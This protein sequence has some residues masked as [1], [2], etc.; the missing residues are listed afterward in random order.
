[1]IYGFNSI[2]TYLNANYALIILAIL[3]YCLWREV[4]AALAGGIGQL[5][6][7]AGSSWYISTGES[8][9]SCPTVWYIVAAL[10]AALFVALPA[11]SYEISHRRGREAS[12]T[13]LSI[14]CTLFFMAGFANY[15]VLA[16]M[17]ASGATDVAIGS[18][19][20]AALS[21]SVAVSISKLSAYGPGTRNS[22]R[23]NYQG[24]PCDN[25]TLRGPVDQGS[26]GSP[27]GDGSDRTASRM[28]DADAFIAHGP[29]NSEQLGTQ[30]P[31]HTPRP[32]ASPTYLFNRNEFFIFRADHLKDLEKLLRRSPPGVLKGLQVAICRRLGRTPIEGDEH[33]FVQAYVIQFRRRLEASY[34]TYFAADRLEL[35][36]A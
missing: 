19:V 30:G 23:R 24:L 27:L 8:G 28:P 21:S 10:P 15:C 33:G 22:G 17:N 13:E 29:A 9:L 4:G 32:W 25:G 3:A 31:S 16:L 18:L 14:F 26:Q 12:A 5:F 6:A 2:L 20:L 36:A 7:N 35:A 1:M 11:A 34:P